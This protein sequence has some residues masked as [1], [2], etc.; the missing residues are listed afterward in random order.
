MAR[1]RV[2]TAIAAVLAGVVMPAVVVGGAASAAPSM[3]EGFHFEAAQTHEDFCGVSG[4]TVDET[5]VADGSFRTTTRGPD[6]LSNFVEF[7][8]STDTWTN[9][10]TGE[11]VTVLQSTKF[12][13]RKVTDNGDG[14]LT[15][16]SEF[17]GTV[18]YYQDGQPIARA[19]GILV[20]FEFVFGH[21][22]T[23]TDPSDDVFLEGRQFEGAGRMVDF[24]ATIVQAIG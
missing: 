17:V 23:P 19:A 13:D 5:F 10:A 20:R 4:L 24:C 1:L 14:T 8:D 21:A 16:L 7:D 3:W 9:R 18:V 15:V 22:G 6:G 12:V 11:T 2:V